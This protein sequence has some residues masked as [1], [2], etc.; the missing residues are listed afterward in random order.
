MS[1]D[2]AKRTITKLW[3]QDCPAYRKS[4]AADRRKSEGW[5]NE[6]VGARGAEVAVL[7]YRAANGSAPEYMSSYFVRVANVP[8]R[9]RLRSSIIPINL[10][11]H[12][13]ISLLS[14]GGPSQSSPPI[15][16][17]V[18]LRALLQHRRSRFSGS[19]SRLT[20]FGVPTLT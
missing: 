1:L 14:A 8:P 16:G 15:F 3:R 11:C 9:L 20:S 10:W 19:V 4:S 18:F 7:T 17:I 12:P 13:T 2:S 6:T 5:Y